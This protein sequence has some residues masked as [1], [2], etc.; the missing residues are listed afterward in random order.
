MFGAESL[1]LGSQ[2]CQVLEKTGGVDCKYEK[3][4]GGAG[5]I[6]LGFYQNSAIKPA[7]VCQVGRGFSIRLR[8]AL[9]PVS[10]SS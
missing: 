2:F 7:P 8:W 10:G 1:M 9:N 5:L 6:D 3:K 4:L